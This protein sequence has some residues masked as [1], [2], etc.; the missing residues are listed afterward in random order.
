MPRP[1][2]DIEAGRNELLETMEGM[3]RQRGVFD[4]SITDLA[5]QAGMS[6]SNVYRFFESKEALYEACAERWFAD[7]VAIM[8]EVTGSDFPVRDKLYQFFARRYRLMAD[9]FAQ[10]PELFKSYLDIG[11]EHFEVIRGYVDLGDHYLSLIVAEAMEEDYFSSLTIDSTVSLI[12]QMVAP[13]CSPRMMVMT[14]P[15]LNEEKLAQI[16]D[17]IFIGLG[18]GVAAT[19]ATEPTIRIV[20]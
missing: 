12:N 19:G 10:E 16:I 8:E 20:S 13:Y 4:L 14:A 17:A 7:K 3:I 1:Q 2:S 18:K 9:S 15:K 5:A 6:P 11:D